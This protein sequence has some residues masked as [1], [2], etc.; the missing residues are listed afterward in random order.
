[1]EQVSSSA[2]KNEQEEAPEMK[3]E[4]MKEEEMKEEDADVSDTMRKQDATN[5]EASP[6][7][8]TDLEIPIDRDTSTSTS[9]K[10]LIGTPSL[11]RR[12]KG[13]KLLQQELQKHEQDS[14]RAEIARMRSWLTSIG[15]E[16][17][18][19]RLIEYGVTKISIIELLSLEDLLHTGM[20]LQDSRKLL[21]A[22]EG[23][24]QQTKDVAE[25]A[26]TPGK[27]TILSAS[28]GSGSPMSALNDTVSSRTRAESL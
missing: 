7:P 12:M 19:A 6:A 25:A 23:V 1:M 26:Q 4:E 28:V 8:K 3:G 5:V 27:S 21:N 9:T 16:N 20:P 14:A 17:H 11:V 22:I 15:L 24:M 2:V 10:S 18:E 13:E